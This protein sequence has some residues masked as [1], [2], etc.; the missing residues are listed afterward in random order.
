MIEVDPNGGQPTPTASPTETSIVDPTPSSSGDPTPSASPSS[1]EPPQPT[2]DECAANIGDPAV[3]ADSILSI[4]GLT[5]DELQAAQD[6]GY[7]HITLA[8]GSGEFGNGYAF[9]PDLFCGNALDNTVSVL[10]SDGNR[11]YFFGGAGDDTVVESW[12]STFYGGDG[13]DTLQGGDVSGIRYYGDGGNDRFIG[14]AGDEY[15]DMGAGNNTVF[16]GDGNDT[17]IVSGGFSTIEI[18]RAHV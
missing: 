18:G 5:R 2:I 11:D 3:T 14:G 17:I 8:T 16:G 15:I 10:D 12:L 6:S 7:W 4:I 9:S 1:T 13:N